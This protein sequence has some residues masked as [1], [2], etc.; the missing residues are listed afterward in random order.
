MENP[1]IDHLK[2]FSCI[3]CLI[4]MIIIDIVIVYTS[5]DTVYPYTVCV[6]VLIGFSMFGNQITRTSS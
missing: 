5:I 2:A 4:P 6:D 1:K 3:R